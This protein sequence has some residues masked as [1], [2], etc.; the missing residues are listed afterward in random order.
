M[1][2]DQRVYK[3]WMQVAPHISGTKKWWVAPTPKVKQAEQ[4][5]AWTAKAALPDLGDAPLGILVMTPQKN[6]LDNLLGVILDGIEKSGRIKNDKQFEH[7]AITR[8]PEL[9]HTEV[10]I[11]ILSEE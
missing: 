5:I 6:D 11:W 2:I 1:H 3:A 10:D 9:K 4:L 8:H 7:I